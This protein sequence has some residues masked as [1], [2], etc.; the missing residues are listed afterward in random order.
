MPRPGVALARRSARN[1]LNAYTVRRSLGQVKRLRGAAPA[2]V[3]VCWDLDNTI[4]DSGSL[5][6]T[7]RWL[8]DAIVEADPVPGMLDFVA[9]VRDG[10]PE[11]LHVVLSVRSAAMRPATLAWLGRHPVGVGAEAV[12][13][14]PRV[15]A[16]P[17]VWRR[18][19]EGTRLVVVDDLSHGH[20]LQAPPVS[21]VELVAAAREI[22]D[23]YVGL[24]QINAIAAEP[25]TAGAAAASIVAA[26][27]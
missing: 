26:L 23:V 13:F 11:A 22:A 19:G 16:K 1:A 15:T 2:P 25:S 18:L 5:L 3:C 7:G 9:A 4:V 24:E 12:V 27:R 6:R 21:Y 8:E 10:L 20:H 14:V 17:R